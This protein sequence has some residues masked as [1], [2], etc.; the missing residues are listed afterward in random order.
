M[1]GAKKVP[2]LGAKK[3]TGDIIDFDAAEKSAREE[4]ERIAKLGYNPNEEQEET[5]ETKGATPLVSPTP[6]SSSASAPTI[7]HTRQK[8]SAEV[9]RLGMGVA[10]LGFGMVGGNKATA[11]APAT[12]NAGGFGSVGPVK[13]TAAGKTPFTTWMNKRTHPC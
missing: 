11:G 9:E 5:K 10:R 7:S 12:K 2:K 6:V 1:L 8:S 4:A 3:I 13:A